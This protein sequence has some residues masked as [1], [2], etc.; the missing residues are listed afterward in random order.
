MEAITLTS[1][2]KML[3]IDIFKSLRM[4]LSPFMEDR[5]FVMSNPQIFTFLMYAPV[6]MAIASDGVVDEKEIRLLDKI[7]KE[8]DVNTAVNLDLMEVLAMATEP[9][10]I[11]LNEEFNMRVDSE[12]LYLSR[13]MDKYEDDILKATK[14][15]MKLDKNPGSA[16]SLK[17]TFS[18]WFE[19]VIESNAG[20]NKEEE[21]KKVKKYK[22]K[23][24]L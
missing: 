6:S 21:L 15:L 24:G 18:K 14:E 11:L 3:V 2:E 7:T 19:F 4:Y 13:N 9:A 16:T 20:R 12:L 23:I 17:S 8:I 10:E 1:E 5:D 22:E